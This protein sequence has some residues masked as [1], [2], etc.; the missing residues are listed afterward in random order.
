MLVIEQNNIYLQYF[1]NTW[2]PWWQL[3]KNCLPSNTGK[4]SKPYPQNAKHIV[5]SLKVTTEKDMCHR[6]EWAQNYANKINVF[7]CLGTTNRLTL[8][9]TNER[10]THSKDSLPCRPAICA[11]TSHRASLRISSI[12]IKSNSSIS[13]SYYV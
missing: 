8:I 11:Q 6:Q 5:N 9:W 12:I 10:T 4:N 3:H 1:G 7:S 2:T 13:T